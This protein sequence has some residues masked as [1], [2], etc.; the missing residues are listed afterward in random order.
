MGTG[1]FHHF[2]TVLSEGG[3]QRAQAQ[4]PQDAIRQ[5]KEIKLTTACIPHNGAQ[6]LV[7]FFFAAGQVFSLFLSDIT[8]QMENNPEGFI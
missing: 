1:H 8:T 3:G 6:D 5:L 2:N 7:H 4:G